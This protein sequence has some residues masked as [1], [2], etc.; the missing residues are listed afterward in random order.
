MLTPK[1]LWIM[2][3]DQGHVSE[4]PFSF[5]WKYCIYLA[6]LP[7][8]ETGGVKVW[9]MWKVQG[10]TSVRLYSQLNFTKVS[11]FNFQLTILTAYHEPFHH[12]SPGGRK[13]MRSALEIYAHFL[14]FCL[15]E[16]QSSMTAFR[17]H[18]HILVDSANSPVCCVLFPMWD[19]VAKFLMQHIRRDVCT[20]WHLLVRVQIPGILVFWG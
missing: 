3:N 13:V 18:L 2:V 9:I 6:V 8:D 4:D 12:S 15:C 14:L 1:L 17:K 7:G 11:S 16:L 20:S 19:M 10:Y 5:C